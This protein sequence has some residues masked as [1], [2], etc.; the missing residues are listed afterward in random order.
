MKIVYLL[1]NGFDVNLDLETKYIQFYKHYKNLDSKSDSI[2]RLK[3]SIANEDS[4]ADLEFRFGEY[5]LEIESKE[6]F[7][8]VFEDISDNLADYL[9]IQED[10][11]DSIE[12]EKEKLYEYLSF[13]ERSLPVAQKN[14][15]AKL[16]TKWVNHHWNTYVIT[17]NYTKSFEKLIGEGKKTLEIGSHHKAKI[18]YQGIQHIHGYIDDAMVMGVNDISQLLNENFHD[19]PEIINAFVKSQCNQAMQ[20]TIDDQCKQHIRTANLICI[21]GSSL[22]L[23]DKLWWE[24]IGNQLKGDCHLIIFGYTTEIIPLRRDYKKEIIRE[25]IKKS[26]LEKTNLTEEEKEI[27]YP[28]IF[29]GINRDLFKMV[30]NNEN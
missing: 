16:R 19:E 8:E 21:Y 10:K 20:H 13:P 1:G 23:T 14:E 12:I 9:K 7:I 5:T 17:L 2:M 29:V 3:E 22:G 18:N 28:K 15:V 26:F 24:T 6:E 11:V 25:N 30:K 27:V 4:W